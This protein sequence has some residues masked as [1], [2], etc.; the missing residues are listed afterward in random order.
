[1]LRIGAITVS[2]ALALSAVFVGVGLLTAP[3]GERYCAER[4]Q[5]FPDQ[6]VAGW[7]GDQLINAAIIVNTARTLP[8]QRRRAHHRQRGGRSSRGLR[9]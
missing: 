2:I 9:A 4:P 6:G 7:S 8:L 1:M 5:T 3:R